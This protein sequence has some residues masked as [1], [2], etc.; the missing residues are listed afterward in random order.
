MNAATLKEKLEVAR[1]RMLAAESAMER[2]LQQI[3]L[4]PREDKSIA[5]AALSNAL[6][7]TKAARLNLLA[8]EK[9]VADG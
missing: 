6:A 7:E 4:A 1:Q 3:Q 5:S 9:P 8:L 2:A